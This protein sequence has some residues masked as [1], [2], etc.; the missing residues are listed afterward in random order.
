[1]HKIVI[2]SKTVTIVMMSAAQEQKKPRSFM[3][4]KIWKPSAS[5]T[6]FPDWI[7]GMCY[8]DTLQVWFP[9]HWAPLLIRQLQRKEEHLSVIS[10]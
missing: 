4:P 1:M 6:R 3:T 8:A 7:G 2:P 10:T 9:A 5:A